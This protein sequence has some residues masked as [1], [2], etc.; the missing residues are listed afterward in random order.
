VRL[1]QLLGLLLLASAARADLVLTSHVTIYQFRPDATLVEQDGCLVGL[2][3]TTA[4]GDCRI[5]VEYGNLSLYLLASGGG[6]DGCSPIWG[7][8]NEAVIGFRDRI[9]FYGPEGESA[10]IRWITQDQQLSISGFLDLQRDL[11][12]LIDFNKPYDLSVVISGST[13]A[14]G[15]WQNSVWWDF[16]IL[17]FQAFNPGCDVYAQDDSCGPLIDVSIHTASGFLYGGHVP[18]PASVTLVVISLL[19]LLPLAHRERS[20]RSPDTSSDPTLSGF[21]LRHVRQ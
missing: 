8:T 16:T 17:G 18:E 4:F 5:T 19:C 9:I 15:D 13:A 20:R 1:L 21:R 7:T 14:N 6:C 2:G 10:A 11:P 3:G 12:T